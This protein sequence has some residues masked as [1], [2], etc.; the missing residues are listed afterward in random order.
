MA[1]CPGKKPDG[2]SCGTTLYRCKKCGNVGCAQNKDCSNLAFKD[3]SKCTKCGAFS[4]KEA[5]K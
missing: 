3:G 2:R 1:L 4:Q 5:F